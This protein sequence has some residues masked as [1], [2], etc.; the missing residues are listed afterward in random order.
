MDFERILNTHYFSFKSASSPSDVSMQAGRNIQGHGDLFQLGH[1]SKG[2][3]YAY[4]P[5]IFVPVM[6][7]ELQAHPHSI[8]KWLSSRTIFKSLVHKCDH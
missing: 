7:R 3:D 1:V 8:F 4:L 6:F 2:A 5:I